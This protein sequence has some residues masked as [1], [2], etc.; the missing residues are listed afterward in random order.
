MTD[1]TSEVPESAAA[2]ASMARVHGPR[3]RRRFTSMVH[4][5]VGA[6]GTGAGALGCAAAACYGATPLVQGAAGSP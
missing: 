2:P 4:A 5:H 1:V 6:H 3:P